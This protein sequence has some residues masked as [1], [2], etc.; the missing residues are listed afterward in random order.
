ML[1]TRRHTGDVADILAIRRTFIWAK[2]PEAVS[3]SLAYSGAKTLQYWTL[4]WGDCIRLT[5][6]ISS[7]HRDKNNYWKSW[8]SLIDLH[9]CLFTK[10]HPRTQ[11]GWASMWSVLLAISKPIN[12]CRG[13]VTKKEQRGFHTLYPL[14]GK[15]ILATEGQHWFQL[16]DLE[17]SR[18]LPSLFVYL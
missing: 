14:G 11:F 17:S 3:G 1:K 4:L 9:T 2:Q 7:L 16:C 15:Q 5:C 6:G 10:T 8:C 12:M 18:N 13:Y